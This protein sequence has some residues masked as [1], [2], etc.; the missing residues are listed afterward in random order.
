MKMLLHLL[1]N[2]FIQ[3]S[4]INQLRYADK[5]KRRQTMYIYILVVVVL[6]G[7]LAYWAYSLNI[8]F[9]YRGKLTV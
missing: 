8:I 7:L 4:R 5:Q 6:A 1:K 3:V 9:P 2:N